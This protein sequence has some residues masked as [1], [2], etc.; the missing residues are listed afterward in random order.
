MPKDVWQIM[1]TNPGLAQVFNAQRQRNISGAGNKKN[2][3]PQHCS[4]KENGHWGVKC[5][6]SPLFF[7]P[8]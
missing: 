5:F 4:E 8:T 2:D 6:T 1:K 3:S 7:S